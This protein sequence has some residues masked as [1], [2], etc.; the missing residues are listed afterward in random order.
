VEQADLLG[1][2]EHLAARAHGGAAV[3][4]HGGGEEGG[5]RA[6]VDAQG[7]PQAALAFAEPAAVGVLGVVGLG[8]GEV[9]E[10]E[11]EVVGVDLRAQA[12]AARRGEEAVD[13][14]L[15]AGPRGRHGE[16]I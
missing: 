2:A 7:D 16:G 6:A 9:A 1:E 5:G 15:H 10:V 8:R 12:A 14:G 3:D 11:R 4:E 13:E